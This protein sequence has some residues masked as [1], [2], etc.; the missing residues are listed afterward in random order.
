MMNMMD[1]M[2]TGRRDDHADIFRQDQHDG[3]DFVS[4]GGCGGRGVFLER[5]YGMTAD[6]AGHAG[7]F[8]PGF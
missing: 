4:H 2:P 6:V 7:M 5:A 1:M 8:I 3:H